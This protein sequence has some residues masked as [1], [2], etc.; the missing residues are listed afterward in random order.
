MSVYPAGK[1]KPYLL[2]FIHACLLPTVLFSF[3]ISTV[4]AAETIIVTQEKEEYI[5][6]LGMDILEDKSGK[7]TLNDILHPETA[8]FFQQSSEKAPGFGFSNSSYWAR[9]KIKSSLPKDATYYIE[10]KYP[11]LDHVE[12]YIQ[13]DN[14]NVRKFIV[15]DHYPFHQRILEYTNFVFPVSLQPEKEITCYLLCRTTSSVNLPLVLL[16]PSALVKTTSLEHLMQGIYFGI[17]IVMILYNLFLFISIRDIIYLYYVLFILG[18]LFF[19][20][21]LNGFSFQYLWPDSI[22]WAN[23]NLPFFI[24][25]AYMF[26]ALFTRSILDTGEKLPRADKILCFLQYLAGIGMIISLFIGYSLSIKLATALCFTLPV[27]I[28]CGIKIMLTGYRPAIYYAVAWSVS[29]LSIVIYSAKTFALLPNIFITKWSSQFGSAWEVLLLAISLADRFHLLQEEK[30]RVQAE[31]T[32]CLKKANAKL[33]EKNIELLAANR[34]LNELNLELEDRVASRTAEL[35]RT[36]YELSQE[37]MERKKAENQAQAASLAKSS[38]L[39]NM[40]H[41]IR[42]PMNA[43]IGL[44]GLALT[45]NRD[46]KI[47]NYLQIIA[48]AGNTLLGIINDIL[49]FSKIES[50]KLELENINFSLHS[51]MA[52][53]SSMFTEK[54]GKQNIKLTVTVADDVPDKLKGDPLRLGQIII[55]L[56][57]NSLKFTDQGEVTVEINR[58][59][60]NNGL[61]TLFVSVTDT[62]V[63][64]SDE[65]ISNLFTAFSQA[66]N[67]TTRKYGGTGLG[68]TI[69]R[70][71]VNLMGGE[72]KVAS[73]LGKGSTF[74]FTAVFRPG[75]EQLALTD[76]KTNHILQTNTTLRGALVLLVEDNEINQQV[77]LEILDSFGIQADTANNGREAIKAVQQKKYAA[78]LMDI[79]MPEMD[80]LEATR[81]IR[82]TAA[83]RK[84]PVIAMTAHAMK[85]D[86]EKCM[87]AGMD[88]YL[89]KPI[90]PDDLFSVLA[91]WIKLE[92]RK[93]TYTESGS[94]SSELPGINI[95][96][97]QKRLNNN[98]KLLLQLLQGFANDYRRVPEEINRSVEQGHLEAA[99][100][101]VHN[102]KGVA[103]NLSIYKVSKIASDIEKNIKGNNKISPQQIKQLQEELETACRSISRLA[104]QTEEIIPGNNIP[105][106]SFKQEEIKNK[107]NLLL[108]LLTGNDLDAEACLAD[109]IKSIGHLDEIKEEIRL[110][111]KALQQLDFPAARSRV[112]KIISRLGF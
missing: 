3:F 18:F 82:H 44:S 39:A 6:G 22:W 41:E 52:N 2:F 90:V 68:L 32:V 74:Y 77:A 105:P 57:N 67:S 101:L 50:G 79:Q 104:G 103:A 12:L 87:E 19:Q 97:A 64:L 46:D 28:F 38:F 53:I 1:I 42:T 91:Q 13:D 11:M 54:A 7:L 14:N 58:S 83:D 81:I 8:K 49:D 106:V 55:N 56:V 47:K 112:N 110:A 65:Q 89:A 86:R 40:S 23:N 16:S 66:D 10:L 29:L 76:K 61:I 92:P 48:N 45:H 109:I 62:G 27:H 78:I 111:H 70:Q 69:C 99:H 93:S 15:G 17:V 84:L 34:K 20:L 100:R 35:S 73:T 94:L 75:S 88:D 5:L 59:D 9:I 85:S 31:Y 98:K 21:S 43:I 26:G 51:V 36:N 63:G 72:I 95:T 30:K 24:F 37:A 107:L 96:E 25:F 4:S 102:L 33:D 80:G 60:V 71:L 108:D